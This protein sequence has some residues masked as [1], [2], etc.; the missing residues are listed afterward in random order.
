MNQKKEWKILNQDE[1]QKCWFF[2]MRSFDRFESLFEKKR[3]SD[4]IR[5]SL[6]LEF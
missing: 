6:N 3:L 4:T 1:F 2:K 5:A